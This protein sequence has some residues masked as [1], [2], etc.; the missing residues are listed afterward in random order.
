MLKFK[1]FYRSNYCIILQVTPF[2]CM[3]R[4][5]VAICVEIIAE[6]SAVS[7]K[8]VWYY[9]PKCVMLI[10]LFMHHIDIIYIK[11]IMLL[12]EKKDNRYNSKRTN[13]KVMF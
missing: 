5:G 1:C 12:R 6:I 10:N 2:A 11:K 4:N 13:W 3:E 9:D 8:F 7:I